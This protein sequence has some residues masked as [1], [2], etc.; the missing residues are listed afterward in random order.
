MAKKKDE[1]DVLVVRDEKTGEISVVAGLNADGTPKRTPAK[2][3]NTPDFLR[4]DRNSD[5]MDSFFRNFFR[6]CKEPSRFGFYRIAADQVENLLGVMKELL[7]DPEANKEILSAHKVDTSNY[8]KEAKQSEGQAKET[9]S[10]DDASKTQANTEKENVSS[11]QTNE[12]ENDMEQKPEQTVTGQQAQTAPGVKQNLISGNDVNLQELG[13]KYGIDFNSMNEKDMKA[14]LNYGKT[15]LV[16]VKPTF[17]GEQIEI[18]ARLSFR[19]DDND[20]LQ[21]VP[22]FV[23]NE[24]KL[25]VAY[26]GYT[27]TPE[28]KKNLLQNGNLGKVVDFPDKNT[29]ELRPHFISIDRLTNEIVDIPTNKVRIPDTIGKTPI[30]KDDK[31]VLYSG[32]PLRKEIELAN[33]RKFT[34]LLQ[35]NVEQRGV[36]FVPGS[37]RQAQGQKQNGDKKQTADKQE[38]KAEGDTG[39]QKKQQDPNHWLNEDGTIR[40]LN[41]Y[42]KKELTEQQK[43]DYVAGKTIEIKEVPNKNG[44]GTYTAYVKFD[45][46][47][48]QPR[49]YRN[50]PD[51][52]Q[53]KEQIPTNENKTQVAVNEQGKTNEATKHTKEPLKPGQSAPKN[54]KQQKEQTAEAQKPKRKA[55]SVKM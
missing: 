51:L 25:D 44:S 19:K 45:F 18:Q 34:P 41:T 2:A 54:E 55:R 49:S 21:L 27:F 33:G 10:S 32:V 52:K 23:R 37:T 50:N 16:I 36:E 31:R 17:G 5:L 28:D 35:V 20:Q 22:H 30:T 43:D 40:R 14:L 15:G 26:K 24:P 46:D 29:G 39:G 6:Q 47:K 11:E 7:K 48:M 4:F 53:A 42:F 9:A 12:K 38:Q 8:E 3:E 1:K 13:A